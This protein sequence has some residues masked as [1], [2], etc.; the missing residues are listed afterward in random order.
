MNSLLQAINHMTCICI[1]ENTTLI[2]PARNMRA[3]FKRRTLMINR[4]TT[5][6]K[7]L[8]SPETLRHADTGCSNV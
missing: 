5:L 4:V 1:A 8:T 3:V 6:V 2:I 7:I